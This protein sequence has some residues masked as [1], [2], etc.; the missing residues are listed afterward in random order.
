MALPKPVCL[1]YFVAQFSLQYTEGKFH[2]G[3]DGGAGAF[4]TLLSLAV[5]CKLGFSQ[6]LQHSVA[7]VC[8]LE[9]PSISLIP[10]RRNCF[11]LVWH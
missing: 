5:R 11:G 1:E 6:G 4:M 10:L 7:N 3:M 2:L 9:Q 8:V